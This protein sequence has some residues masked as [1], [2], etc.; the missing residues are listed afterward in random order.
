VDSG[1]R[2]GV[3]ETEASTERRRA[4]QDGGST[5]VKKKEQTPIIE[6]NVPY[7]M[8]KYP[9][10]KLE[11]G[12]SFELFPEWSRAAVAVSASRFSKQTNRKF[13]IRKTN[14]G[15]LRCWRIE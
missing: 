15:A 2:G 5:M 7:P 6:S 1:T 4:R 14:E 12:D 11:V 3:P 13:S 10:A 8:F 9:F